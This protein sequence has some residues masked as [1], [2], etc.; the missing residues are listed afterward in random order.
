MIDEKQI[1]EAIAYCSG[2][3][4]PNRNDAIL[5]AAC[6]IIQD[7]FHDATETIDAGYSLAPSPVVE[8][9]GLADSPVVGEYGR[10]DFLQAVA[11]KDSAAM[12]AVMDELMDT[13]K[14]VNGRV[15]DGIMRRIR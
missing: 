3:V 15:Y 11:G 12:W 13:L 2:K 1:Q 7:H 8:D 6:Y 14:M 9:G 4:E 10:S 5:L